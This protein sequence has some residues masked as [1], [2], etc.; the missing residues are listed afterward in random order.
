V[1]GWEGGTCLWQLEDFF[2]HKCPLWL[3]PYCKPRETLLFEFTKYDNKKE[4]SYIYIGK[5]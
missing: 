4:I 1:Y 2:S 5:I 3:N